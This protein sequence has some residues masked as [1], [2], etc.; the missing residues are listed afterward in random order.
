[1][2]PTEKPPEEPA[3]PGDPI[4]MALGALVASCYAGY[5]RA[6]Q[7]ATGR[8]QPAGDASDAADGPAPRDEDGAAAAAPKARPAR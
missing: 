2:T 6:K 5:R 7:V 3:A 1:M 8:A 4:R